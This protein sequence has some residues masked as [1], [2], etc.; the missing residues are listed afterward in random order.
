[1]GRLGENTDLLLGEGYQAM[2]E[3]QSVAYKALV[4]SIT[5]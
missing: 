4:E 3:E 1:M 5:Q 2:R